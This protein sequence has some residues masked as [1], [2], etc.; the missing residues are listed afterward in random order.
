MFSGYFSAL[1]NYQAERYMRAQAELAALRGERA[2]KAARIEAA[3]ARKRR[4][5][6][7]LKSLLGMPSIQ[8]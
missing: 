5:E 7:S 8:G 6:A 4:I 3:K 1:A 2:A